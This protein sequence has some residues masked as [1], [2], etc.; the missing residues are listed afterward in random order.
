MIKIFAEGSPGNGFFQVFIGG[1]KDA[2]I[3]FEVVC[4]TYGPYFLFLEGAKQLHLYTIR[5]VS[6]FVEKERTAVCFPKEACFVLDSRGER[7]FFMAEELAGRQFHRQSP[8]IYGDKRSVCPG[9]LFVNKA[10]HM[11]FARTAFAGN[12]HRHLRRRH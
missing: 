3:D 5:K 4:R 7:A 2:D 11:L 6:H 10:R 1:G 12:H 9:A 8:A